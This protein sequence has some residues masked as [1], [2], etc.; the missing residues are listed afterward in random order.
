MNELATYVAQRELAIDIGGHQVQVVTRP[1]LPPLDQVM[2]AALLLADEVELAQGDQVLVLGCGHGALGAALALRAAPGT[3]TLYDD[4]AVALD[5]AERTLAANSLTNARVQRS[6]AVAPCPPGS[7]AVAVL[8][9][10]PNRRLSRRWLLEA[11]MALR[12][13]GRLYLAGPNNGGIQPAIDDAAALFGQAATIRYK[14]RNRVALAVKQHTE[15]TAVDWASEPGVAPRTWRVF[16]L[17]T[18][19]G[20][21]RMETAAGVFSYEELDAGTALLLDSLPDLRGLR[22]LDVG[23]GYGVIGITAARL[24][25]SQVDMVDVSLTAVEAAQRNSAANAAPQARALVS[26]LYAAVRDE[27]YDLVVSNPPF[28]HGKQVTYD[29]TQ[30]LIE[31][32]RS[33][34]RPGGRLIVVANRFIRYDRMMGVAYERVERLATTNAYHVLAAG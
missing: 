10:P 4:I 3:V 29:I 1:G 32:A 17:A 13:G 7:C 14:A 34:L 8:D 11:F 25:A 30:A 6:V 15:P 5:L 27:R 16:D 18:R 2:P 19:A 28:H 24:G 9:L 20:R 12:P 26:D 33:M 22:L 31:G 21:L 23:C